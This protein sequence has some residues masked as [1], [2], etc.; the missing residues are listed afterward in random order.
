MQS[1]KTHSKMTETHST[2]HSTQTHSAHKRTDVK[3]W[4]NSTSH[5]WNTGKMLCCSKM[6]SRST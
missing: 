6:Q 3:I 2:P 5:D 1:D 4:R